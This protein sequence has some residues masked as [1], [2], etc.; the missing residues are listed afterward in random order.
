MKINREELLSIETIA[1]RIKYVR[2][3]QKFTQNGVALGA[4]ISQE[5]YSKIER[6]I[7]RPSVDRLYDIAASLKVAVYD[8][9]PET[10][11]NEMLGNDTVFSR[12]QQLIQRWWRRWK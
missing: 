12:V 1:G 3:Q 7:T 2:Q 4:G 5:A 11:A 10:R 9:M 8:L 6:G